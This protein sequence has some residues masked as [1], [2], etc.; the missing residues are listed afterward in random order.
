[1]LCCKIHK[2]T[3]ASEITFCAWWLFISR[4]AADNLVAAQVLRVRVRMSRATCWVRPGSKSWG[5][6]RVQYV[7]L[8]LL[9]HSWGPY[10]VYMIDRERDSGAPVGLWWPFNRNMPRNDKWRQPL[11]ILDAKRAQRGQVCCADCLPLLCLNV[12]HI[13]GAIFMASSYELPIARVFSILCLLHT[14]D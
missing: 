7:T 1:M 6:K 4:T 10:P 12:A 14:F 9:I 8:R 13:S 3:E 2:Q 11:S 5:R